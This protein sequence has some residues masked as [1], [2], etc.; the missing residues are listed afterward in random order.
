ME[1]IGILEIGTDVDEET[2]FV[3][4]LR[5]TGATFREMLG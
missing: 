4:R 1:T 5:I 2:G 3:S